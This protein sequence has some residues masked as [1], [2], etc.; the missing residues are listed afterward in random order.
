MI[1]EIAA[2]A[3]RE[4]RGAIRLRRHDL[5]L[6]VRVDH[7]WFAVIDGVGKE[8]DRLGQYGREVLA[9][10]GKTGVGLSERTG[11]QRVRAEHK[12]RMA[13][14]PAIDANG[15]VVIGRRAHL[16]DVEPGQVALQLA[17]LAPAEEQDVDHDVGAG[18]GAEAAFRQTDRTEEIGI[19]GDQL[20]RGAIHLVHRAVRGDEGGEAAR[21]QQ[22]DRLDEK[23]VVEAQALRAQGAIR[24]DGAI[25]EGRIADRKVEPRR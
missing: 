3:R 15:A 6:A 16:L 2:L 5:V 21:L 20:A 25:G 12:A 18:I 7:L 24:T 4:A 1:E 8:G 10:L 11:G 23:K 17:V 14:K 13:R 9:G 22:L 19:L